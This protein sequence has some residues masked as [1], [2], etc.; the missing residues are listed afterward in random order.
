MNINKVIANEKTVKEYKPKDI[1]EV[2]NQISGWCVLPRATAMLKCF[3]LSKCDVSPPAL[4]TCLGN[5][6]DTK[7]SWP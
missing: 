4:T 7:M 5:E 2:R 3:K 1:L 6:N